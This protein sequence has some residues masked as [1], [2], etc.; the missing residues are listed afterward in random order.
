MGLASVVILWFTKTE[1]LIKLSKFPDLMILVAIK[2]HIK[3]N[4]GPFKF[5]FENKKSLEVCQTNA[6]NIFPPNFKVNN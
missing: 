2:L 4:I 5:D 6:S 3:L 1:G